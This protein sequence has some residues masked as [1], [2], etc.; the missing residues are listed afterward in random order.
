M[1]AENR[2]KACD[3]AMEQINNLR[4]AKMNLVCQ[5]GIIEEDFTNLGLYSFFDPE[6]RQ[7]ALAIKRIIDNKED[8]KSSEKRPNYET[9]IPFI[10]DRGTGKTSAM[11]SVLKALH[12]TP[13]QFFEYCEVPIEEIHFVCFDMIDVETMRCNEN[14]ISLILSH[15]LSY[16][17]LLESDK[18]FGAGSYENHSSMLRDI[19]R[20]I[21]SLFR[22]IGQRHIKS[23]QFSYD[24]GLVG[25]QKISDAQS[26]IPRFQSLVS[27]FTEV[28]K[29]FQNWRGSC[30][31]VLALDDVD[32]FLGDGVQKDEQFI[33]LE[34][35]YDFMKAPN[36][37]VMM[38]F[39]ERVLRRNCQNHFWKFFSDSQRKQ[40]D[41][42]AAA[43]V[44]NLARQFM[45]KLFPK[46]Q[47]IYMPNFKYLNS[48]NQNNLRIVVMQTSDT[49]SI[50]PFRGGEVLPVKEFMLKMIAYKMGVYF[51][52]IG[53]KKHFLEP[54][55]LREL[56]AMLFMVL[57]LKD[58]KAKGRRKENENTAEIQ[59]QNR[60]LFLNYLRNEFAGDHLVSE[61]YNRFQKLSEIPLDRQN[62]LLIDEIR[63]YREY[64][65]PNETDLGYL[66]KT[67][68]E[69]WKYSYGE[70]LQNLYFSTRITNVSG[71]F[72]CGRKVSYPTSPITLYSK[73]F[74]Q[75][76]LGCDS[77]ILNQ[78]VLMN[79]SKEMQK[80]LGSSIAG[81]WANDMLP[82]FWVEKKGGI[83]IGSISAPISNFLGFEI[84][85][86]IQKQM[87]GQ[88]AENRKEDEKKEE[89]KEL[90]NYVDALILLGMFFTHFPASGLGIK[91]EPIPYSASEKTIS[92]V[93]LSS[94]VDYVCFNVLNP[95][96]N[97]YTFAA[98]ERDYSQSYLDYIFKKLIGMSTNFATNTVKILDRKAEESQQRALARGILPEPNNKLQEYFEMVKNAAKIAEERKD[99][100]K[101]FDTKWRTAVASSFAYFNE[102]LEKQKL[103]LPI[104]HF[105]M[106]YNII[107]RMANVSYRDIP[108]EAH[109]DEAY[110]YV[111]RLYVSI[112]KELGY[113]DKA[114]GE[115]SKNFAGSFRNS[116][117]FKILTAH[118]GSEFYNP[119]FKEL[120]TQMMQCIGVSSYEREQ[121]GR[122]TPNLSRLI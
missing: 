12:E 48:A 80:V 6:Y 59:M 55:N 106:M 24:Q 69:R 43:E 110:D 121:S 57:H 85:K 21:D 89:E 102:H 66:S 119:Y 67:K 44:D 77:L 103:V 29:R 68:K 25:L 93:L 74:V 10:G 87:L 46:E 27:E 51:D 7:A 1:T 97:T 14:I 52:I 82:N 61:E 122:I 22:T 105:D 101:E 72:S 49:A 94:S 39:N 5:S 34:Q 120:F 28:V 63:N 4:K 109:I 62:R 13:S 26:A 70:L 84:P 90:K 79:D 36:L 96:L 118:P 41:S 81:R 33:L 107:K 32:L 53:S 3:C 9:V 38:T 76:I 104:Q 11:V 64:A 111:V 83:P 95:V 30:Y 112:A 78:M 99:K 31:L 54:R 56:G 114:Y 98:P 60:E 15:M 16:L 18:K 47:K 91:H 92:F 75:C 73:E 117:F 88:T 40:E 19:Y 23:E 115:V 17:K 37:I 58:P 50:Q 71:V 116:L 86:N 2:R 42:A 108:S 113:Q 100:L 35:I 8:R 20:D 65:A 45:S